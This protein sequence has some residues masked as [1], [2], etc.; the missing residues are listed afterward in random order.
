MRIFCS[1][2]VT[3]TVID[4]KKEE[5][6]RN[7]ILW[8]LNLLGGWK[9][10]LSYC[11][12]FYLHP[13]NKFKIYNMIEMLEKQAITNNTKGCK[14][15]FELWCDTLLQPLLKVGIVNKW[16]C[17]NLPFSKMLLNQII[18][19]TYAMLIINSSPK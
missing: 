5:S 9:L 12:F 15:E 14:H 17:M 2:D 6:D 19:F 13:H 8:I 10:T 18:L 1:C 16:T 11:K 4:W 3:I 7:V